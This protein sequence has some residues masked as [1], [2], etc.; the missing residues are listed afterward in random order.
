MTYDTMRAL[1]P[2]L[3]Y[4]QLT[5]YGTEGPETSRKAFDITAWWA[6][7][8][9]MDFIRDQGQTPLPAAPGMGDHATAMSMFGAIMTGLYRRERTGEGCHVSTSLAANGAWANGMA[10]QGVIAGVDLGAIR[11]AK[12]WVNPFTASYPTADGKFVV[13]AVINRKREWPRLAAALGHPEWVDDPRFVDHTAQMHHR[14]ELIDLIGTETVRFSQDALMAAF[15]GAGITCGRVQPM[16]DVVHDAQLVANGIV[17]PTD[18]PDE[19]YRHTI[20]SPIRIREEQKRVPA[21]APDV[22]A[23]TRT[24]LAAN[25]FSAEQIETLVQAGVVVATDC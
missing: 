13:L 14:Y 4:A 12:G 10:L 2:R 19:H 15:D 18:D 17:V 20:G 16:G 23:H 6:R 8:G 24:V 3:V 22:G 11:Q 25:G 21:R 5:G 9:L 1:N 7:S